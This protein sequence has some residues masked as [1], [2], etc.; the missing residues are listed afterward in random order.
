M[1][2]YKV[3]NYQDGRVKVSFTAYRLNHDLDLT[4][5]EWD[6]FLKKHPNP[7]TL[8]LN[9]LAHKKR[10]DYMQETVNNIKKKEKKS[11]Y[12]KEPGYP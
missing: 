2:N 3:K 11:V 1:S 8:T 6:A 4:Q 5:K 7:G 9:A 10:Q 12:D